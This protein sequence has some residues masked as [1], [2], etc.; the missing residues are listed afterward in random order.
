MEFSMAGAV[1]A[2]EALGSVE[3]DEESMLIRK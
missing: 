1:D 3:G 2:V